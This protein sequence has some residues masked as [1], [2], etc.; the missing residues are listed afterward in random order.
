LWHVFAAWR[1][2]RRPRGWRASAALGAAPRGARLGRIAPAVDGAPPSEAGTEREQ[3]DVVASLELAGARGLVGRG[4]ARA[5]RRVA[6]VIHRHD[7]LVRAQAGGLD[8]VH[9][10]VLAGVVRDQPGGLAHG[11][12]G[13]AAGLDDAARGRLDRE[14]VDL[15]ELVDQVVLA[16]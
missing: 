13:A 8:G 7:H 11:D 5:T 9:D 12:A 14:L 16:G 10:D 1:L 2:L 4:R 15:L 6:R 3:D